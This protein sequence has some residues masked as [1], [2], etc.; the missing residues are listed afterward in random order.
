MYRGQCADP[1]RLRASQQVDD[2]HIHVSSPRPR[3][4]VR[5]GRPWAKPSALPC[6]TASRWMAT[7]T[8][9]TLATRR[10]GAGQGQPTCSNSS[11]ESRR[12]NIFPVADREMIAVRSGSLS[13]QG[14]KRNCVVWINY[15]RS[16]AFGFTQGQGSEQKIV[17]CCVNEW[18]PF[19]CFRIHSR[20]RTEKV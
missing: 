18:L 3:R 11:T 15:C 5:R 4:R 19:A 1:P 17:L 20:F 8:S 6:M 12:G 10:R 2:D 16:P 14:K 7:M 13:V 9:G